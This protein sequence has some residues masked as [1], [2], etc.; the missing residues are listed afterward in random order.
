MDPHVVSVGIGIL[1]V[2]VIVRILSTVA[3]AFGDNLNVKEKVSQLSNYFAL[4]S[5]HVYS[6]GVRFFV[7]DGKGN[8]AGCS[9]SSFS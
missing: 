1:S 9:G 2:G 5:L 4:A 7:V 3:I 8:R 6:S